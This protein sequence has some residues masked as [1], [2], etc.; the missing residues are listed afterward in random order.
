M[1]RP[2]ISIIFACLVGLML[3]P[4]CKKDFSSNLSGVYELSLNTPQNMPTNGNGATITL[5][6][7]VDNRCPPNVFCLTTGISYIKLKFDDK[8]SEQIFQLCFELCDD[9]QKLVRL[10]GDYYFIHMER[11]TAIDNSSS[12]QINR[13]PVV[14][15]R[16]I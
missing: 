16:K 13:M 7:I 12:T 5:L 15:V 1:K 8:K 9:K 4:A 3:Y 11:L 14:S 6:E 2:L 10:N